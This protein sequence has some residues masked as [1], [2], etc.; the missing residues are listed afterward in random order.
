[1]LRVFRKEEEKDLGEGQS[2]LDIGVLYIIRISLC[3]HC[4]VS[5]DEH[6]DREHDYHLS[7]VISYQRLLCAT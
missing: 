3:V 4:T 7:S 6:Y 1:M 5:Y 2:I